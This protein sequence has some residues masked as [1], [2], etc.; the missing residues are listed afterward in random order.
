MKR[1][2]EPWVGSR[3]YSEG[4]NGA[5]ILI[6]GESHYGK[7]DEETPDFTQIVIR[8]LG[9]QKR[10]R[11]FTVVQKTVSNETGW[12]SDDQRRDFWERVAYYNYI[13]KLV[14]DWSRIRPTKQ[15]WHD[16]KEPLLSTLTELSP[17]IL[18]ILGF[19]LYENLPELPESLIC[20]PIQHP[21][22]RGYR[23][24]DWQP[25]IQLAIR[26]IGMV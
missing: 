12:I 20:C 9:Q 25:D 4:Y 16:A 7:P 8:A 21:S 26:K 22:S 11:F 2:F 18:I 15:M 10:F 14:G 6:L 23:Y 24:A 5:R 3:Y 1:T 13:Q 19:E 17:Q